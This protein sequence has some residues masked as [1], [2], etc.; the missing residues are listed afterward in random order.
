M[1]IKP[2]EPML[3]H[4][5]HN[6]A[7]PHG[8]PLSG[9][10]E[11]TPCCNMA[12][13]M[14]YVRMTRQE[15]EAIAPLHSADEWLQLGKKA[16]DMG[17]LFLLLTGGEPFLRPDFRQ[18]LQGLHQMGLVISINTN[19]T[20]IDEETVSWLRQTP[21]TRLNITLYGASDETYAR[22]CGN[23]KGYTQVTRAIRLLRE[24]GLTVKLNCS[25]TPYNVSDLDAM[26]AYAQQEDLVIQAASYMFPPLRRDRNMVGLN[27]RFSPREAA[28]Q[29]ARIQCLTNGENTFLQHMKENSPMELTL[30]PE[31]DCDSIPGEE[32]RCRA[33]KTS[34]WITWDGRMLPCGMFPGEG[35]ENVFQ[36][37]FSEIWNRVRQQTAAIRLPARCAECEAK[38]Q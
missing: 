18:I 2:V 4:Y 10:F 23:P 32:I 30:N 20:M 8:I 36:G 25:V 24:A 7:A 17:M 26:F 5:L 34:F 37:N 14:C 27:D 6:R 31:E 3:S 11:L 21:P 16:R 13:K 38:V 28:Y 35:A 12:C 22:L 9:T 33:G 29:M 15:Q 1:A 19:G